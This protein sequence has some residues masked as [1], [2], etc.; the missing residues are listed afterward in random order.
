MNQVGSY[1]GERALEVSRMNASPAGE[2]IRFQVAQTQCRQ[3]FVA[4]DKSDLL[5]G[6]SKEQSEP[7]RA[8]ARTEVDRQTRHAMRSCRKGGEQ[9][10]VDVGA[11]PVTWRWL[12]KLETPSEERVSSGFEVAWG[13]A[14]VTS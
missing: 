3:S 10:G 1:R 9:N 13:A 4:L 11:I 6:R 8:R 2:A 7:D 12:E 14:L 5:G